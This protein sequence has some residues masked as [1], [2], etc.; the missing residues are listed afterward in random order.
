MS[1][2]CRN[3]ILDPNGQGKVL[4][5]GV[6]AVVD[7]DLP[8][9]TVTGETLGTPPTWPR[10]KPS[11]TP[12][13][14]RAPTCT[15]SAA[16]CPNS[17]SAYRPT[18]PTRR[19]ACCIRRRRSRTP[20]TMLLRASPGYGPGSPEILEARLDYAGI[21]M[22]AGWYRTKLPVPEQ[23]VVDP[24]D[25]AEV[26]Q[27]RQHLHR[28]VSLGGHCTRCFCRPGP[29]GGARGVTARRSRVWVRCRHGRTAIPRTAIRWL[30][31]YAV[32]GASSW[33]D[34]QVTSWSSASCAG[35]P[36]SAV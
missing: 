29:G 34:A 23:L 2:P 36:V 3:L 15:R 8:R 10:N 19:S 7:A 25:V 17:S 14:V 4:D 28:I 24:G 1:V 32:V 22:L 31:G 35:E 16:S 5:V 18:R 9:L 13:S 21:L 12:R 11:A 6:A 26:A 20:V 30:A 33:V 27:L